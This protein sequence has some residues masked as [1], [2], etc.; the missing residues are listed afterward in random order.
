MEI[1]I[2]S[3][4]EQILA[5]VGV[6]L[7][8]LVGVGI[9]YIFARIKNDKLQGYGELL[10]FYAEKAVK[11]VAQAEVDALKGAREDGKLTAAEKEGFKAS[12]VETLKAIAPDA[13]LKFMEKGKSDLDTL[14]S[15][16]IESAVKD[17]KGG[18]SS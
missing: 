3:I 14:L 12:A 6:A 9:R 2:S 18:D 7:A 10:A 11:S 15:T 1:L 17:S 5:G 13:I 16:L 8:A 4:L